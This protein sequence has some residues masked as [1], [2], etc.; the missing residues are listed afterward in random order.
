MPL[1][2]STRPPKSE[3]LRSLA[4][5]VVLGAIALAIAI[6]WMRAHPLHRTPEVTVPSAA[7]EISAPAPA[8]PVAPTQPAAPH[9]LADFRGV[10]VSAAVREVANWS[11]YTGDN[12]GHSVV[13]LDKKAATVYAL[14]PSGRLVSSAP[15]LLGLAVGDD[16]EPGIGD[17]PLNQIR[18]DEKTTP[19]GRF[20]AEPGENT[21][22]EDIVWIDYDLALAMHRVI[23]GTPAEQRARRLASADPNER[24]ISFGCINLPPAFYDQVLSPAVKKTGAVVYILPEIK[25]TRQ[26]FGSWDVTQPGA[27]AP[28]DVGVRSSAAH[29]AHGKPK[30][31][32]RENPAAARSTAAG[33]Q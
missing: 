32:Y 8:A 19:A 4:Q 11:F 7:P 10:H 6:P 18:D 9:R 26:V 22:G 20:V 24:R 14:D 12:H 23:K 31:A 5:G 33:A 2:T 25:T 13:I 21:Q 27:H 17:K 30:R 28:A 15:V 16:A 29:S 1:D 3:F